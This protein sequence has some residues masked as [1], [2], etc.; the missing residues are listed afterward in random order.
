MGRDVPDKRIA[1]IA[2]ILWST[3]A[4][5]FLSYLCHR[6][7]VVTQKTGAFFPTLSLLLLYYVYEDRKAIGLSRRKLLL[8]EIL[9]P[10]VLLLSDS[11]W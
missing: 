6:S 7:S 5:L 8:A 10:T 1:N 3:M 4:K 11:T 2:T 9:P